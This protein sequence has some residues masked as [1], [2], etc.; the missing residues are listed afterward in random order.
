[1]R[2]F[3]LSVKRFGHRCLSFVGCCFVI[4]RVLVCSCPW[5]CL[6][7]SVCFVLFVGCYLVLFVDVC[8]V[9]VAWC[10]LCVCSCIV[11]SLCVARC[12]LFVVRC[13]LLV[14]C[15]ML[16]FWCLLFVG[17]RLSC[18]VCCESLVALFNNGYVLGL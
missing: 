16:L 5:L 15:R 10:M 6:C 14:V 1:M 7:S 11:C 12:L 2:C 3:L 18:V 9:C 8:F 17:D 13:L 4:V